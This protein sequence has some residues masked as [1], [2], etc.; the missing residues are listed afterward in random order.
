MANRKLQAFSH[1]KASIWSIFQW[2]FV[3]DHQCIVKLFFLLILIICQI[4]T[5]GSAQGSFKWDIHFW[6]GSNST[7]DEMA[8]AAIKAVELDDYLGGRPVQYREVCFKTF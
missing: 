8:T 2:R 7:L 3:F 6:L 4:K 1:S 5:R